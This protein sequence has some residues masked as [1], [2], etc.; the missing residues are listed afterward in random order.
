MAGLRWVCVVQAK[1]ALSCTSFA[2][3]ISEVTDGRVNS[4]AH[5]RIS[6]RPQ[7]CFHRAT[8]QQQDRAS[9]T[10]NTCTATAYEA[11]RSR[12]RKSAL[13]RYSKPGT[14]LTYTK[15]RLRYSKGDSGPHKKRHNMTG[16]VAAKTARPQITGVT[17]LMNGVTST[18]C[19]YFFFLPSI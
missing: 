9:A 3:L 16:E 13:P 2:C 17:A 14:L 1:L 6:F 15:T 10:T 5:P 12:S 18:T 4:L 8:T 11:R 7:K 19:S